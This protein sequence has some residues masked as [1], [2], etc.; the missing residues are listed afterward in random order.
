MGDDTTDD[1]AGVLETAAAATR[2]A[3]IGR[4]V[5]IV[6]TRRD[7]GVSP[8]AAAKPSVVSSRTA[9]VAAAI[10]SLSA[11]LSLSCTAYSHPSRLGSR[12]GPSPAARPAHLLRAKSMPR[13]PDPLTRAPHARS[14]ATSGTSQR[15]VVGR[16]CVSVVVGRPGW[17]VMALD[18][19]RRGVAVRVAVAACEAAVGVLAARNRRVL[20]RCARPGGADRVA[21]CARRAVVVGGCS[22]TRGAVRRRRVIE[23]PVR[24]D[25]VTRSA[26]AAGVAG[27]LR[28]ARSA[29]RGATGVRERP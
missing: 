21:R 5:T 8:P 14:L 4:S 13:S 1:W 10:A 6:G 27:R 26:G 22:V 18:A 28:V 15:S 20:E 2:V 19:R 12:P 3:R 23:G 9:A 16:S 17:R 25:S 24:T 29:G 7:E 11:C